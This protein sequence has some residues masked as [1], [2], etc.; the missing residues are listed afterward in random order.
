MLCMGDVIF[1]DSSRIN[2]GNCKYTTSKAC[3]EDLLTYIK[4]LLHGGWEHS[5][6]G[7]FCIKV[8]II[9]IIITICICQS[10]VLTAGEVAT[11]KKEGAASARLCSGINCTSGERSPP[12]CPFFGA[13]LSIWQVIRL[14][15]ISLLECKL[16]AHSM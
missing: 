5:I 2:C 15:S 1:L 3:C 11:N 6:N 10:V 9:I 16:H 14:L 13:S 12:Q 7:S 8:F 4:H